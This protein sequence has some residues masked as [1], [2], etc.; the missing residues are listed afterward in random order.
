MLFP[1]FPRRPQRFATPMSSW[2]AS[3]LCEA[4]LELRLP[5]RSMG[6]GGPSCTGFGLPP[7]MEDTEECAQRACLR[8]T[9]VTLM[10]SEMTSE[11]GSTATDTGRLRYDAPGA[12]ALLLAAMLA[13]AVAVAGPLCWLAGPRLSCG[14]CVASPCTSRFILAFALGREWSGGAVAVV[15]QRRGRDESER[16]EA[17][18]ERQEHHGVLCLRL[19]CRVLLGA[20]L[21]QYERGLRLPG[22]NRGGGNGM[23]RRRSVDVCTCMD[24]KQVR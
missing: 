5:G 24:A 16:R 8:M 9:E 17:G 1:F 18:G 13:D 15:Y 14:G 6:L 20:I 2:A 4:V 7:R 22:S 12:W 3:P 11:T 21:S 19:S 23:R 10:H